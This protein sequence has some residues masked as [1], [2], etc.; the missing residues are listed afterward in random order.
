[1]KNV[2]TL[3]S[4]SGLEIVP[5][6]CCSVLGISEIFVGFIYLRGFTPKCLNVIPTSM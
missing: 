5:W 3:L 6:L 2:I 4:Y 1:M